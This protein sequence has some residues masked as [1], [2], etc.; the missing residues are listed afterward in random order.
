MPNSVELNYE[1]TPLGASFYCL[2]EGQK[3]PYERWGSY[4]VI[5]QD[6]RPASVGVFSLLQESEGCAESEDNI[7][8]NVKHEA[9]A[10]LEPWQVEKLGL[11]QLAPVRLKINTKKPLI[12]KDFII[13]YG[14]VFHDGLPVFYPEREGVFLKCEMGEYLLTDPQ[15]SILELIDGYNKIPVENLDNRF[16]WWGAI[17]ELLPG[18]VEVSDFLRKVNVVTPTSF[19]IDFTLDQGLLKIT[20]RFV[21]PGYLDEDTNESLLPEDM[22]PPSV[23]EEFSSNFLKQPRPSVRYGM[24]GQWFVIVPKSVQTALESVREINQATEEEKKAFLQNP[25]SAIREKLE[26]SNDPIITS[27]ELVESLFVETKLF[28][29][30]RIKYIGE[31]HP[32]KGLFIKTEVSQWLPEDGPPPIVG[33]PLKSGIHDVPTPKI[34][35]LLKAVQKAFA[36]GQTEIEFEGKAFPVDEASIVAVE[37]AAKAFGPP[38]KPDPKLGGGDEGSIP[39]P[40]LQVPI[41]YDHIEE[42]GISV[43]ESQL[44]PLYDCLPALERGVN[45]HSHQQDG[46]DWLRAHWEHATPGALLADDM[47]LGKTLQSLAFLSWVK[48]QMANGAC[49]RKPFL[50]VAPTGLL[51]NW[52]EEAEKFLP[53]GHLGFLLKAHGS[54]FSAIYKQGI[55]SA[56]REIQESGWVLTTYET[57]RDKIFA[58]TGVEWAV[59][60]FDEVQKIKN[61]KAMATEM[62]KSLK[63][64]FTLT[65]TGTPVENSLADLWC[66]VDTA[67]PGKLDTLK[68]FAGKYIKNGRSGESEL[69]RLKRVLSFPEYAPIMLR[70]SKDEHWKEKPEKNENI[71]E[72]DMPSIQAKAYSDAVNKARQ[73]K[74]QKGAM[75]TALQA[76]RAISLHPCMQEI[77][78][79]PNE[80]IS[81][82]ARLVALFELL[83][84]IHVTNEKALIFV[85]YREMQSRLAELIQ[86]RYNCKSIMLINGAVAGKKRQ[87]RVSDFQSRESGFD[88]MILSPKAGG[89]GLTLTA[90]THV[91]HLTRWWN[92]AVEDQ[93]SDRAYRIG[94]TKAV[95]VHYPLA[96]HPEIGRDHSFDIKLH[97][98]L[99]KKRS[100]SRTLLAPPAGTNQDAKELFAT[101]VSQ[102]KSNSDSNAIDLESID[103]M[104]PTQFEEFVH[105]RLVQ[106]GYSVRK[107]PWSGDGGADGVALGSKGNGLPNLLIQCKHT[108]T[109]RKISVDAVEQVIN[110]RSRYSDVPNPIEL[111]VVTNGVFDGNAV[112][113]AEAKGVSL[114]DRNALSFV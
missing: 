64:E 13:N 1:R 6:G 53:T 80:Y 34:P 40:F 41:I 98:L 63:A 68:N 29:S 96:V 71:I 101:T 97:E 24:R 60:V 46:V 88:V 18:D 90:A 2:K 11:P 86:V 31:W 114:F 52:E 4:R 45:L 28:L 106:R 73:S 62:A 87:A 75:L 38:H 15:F 33:I 27:E 43:N 105:N 83:D 112:K 5:L 111:W 32:K 9:L 47:G 93:C 113:Q 89:V 12:S 3:I 22:L 57:L 10:R 84:D 91:I 16:Q 8:F 79:D 109:D 94:Q 56:S 54:S 36:Q 66:I 76:L 102:D 77:S 19:T 74:G 44:R 78:D 95:T 55:S 99:M 50:I 58:F 82:S 49:D 107:T 65:L 69:V 17:A 72:A 85:E 61:P 67:Q 37:K 23:A 92:P 14:F 35:A 70:R 42:L 59:V 51:K 104:E 110:S 21:V 100:L 30:E 108:Q 26:E 103:I 20:P 48:L 25:R 7:Y 39:K 81:Q